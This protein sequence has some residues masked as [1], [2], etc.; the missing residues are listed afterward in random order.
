MGQQE[1]P[2]WNSELVLN[3]DFDDFTNW[4]KMMKFKFLLCD[5]H[6]G[7]WQEVIYQWTLKELHFFAMPGGSG[8]YFRRTNSEN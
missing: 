2:F 1:F 7:A 5:E 8:L 3:Q 4:R 6:Q